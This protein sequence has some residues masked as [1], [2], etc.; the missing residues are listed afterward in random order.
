MGKY[1]LDIEEFEITTHTRNHPS[2]GDGDVYCSDIEYVQGV[3][4][5]FLGYGVTWDFMVA[6]KQGSCRD[7]EYVHGVVYCSLGH[8]NVSG[9][10]NVALKQWSEVKSN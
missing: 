9:A 5:C 8:N 4:Y 10:F 1:D 2:R 6:L 7:L 3:V